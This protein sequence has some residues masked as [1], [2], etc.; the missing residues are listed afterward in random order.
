MEGLSPCPQSRVALKQPCRRR[1][2]AP[3]DQS[4]LLC[5][6][7]VQTR[8]LLRASTMAEGPPRQPQGH[9]AGHGPLSVYESAAAF[10]EAKMS[11][12]F[13]GA[14]SVPGPPPSVTVGCLKFAN[15]WQQPHLPWELVVGL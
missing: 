9:G 14:L 4:F 5:S 12:E 6:P 3:L 10:A 2:H 11:L 1:L 8:S 13:G 15:V 7:P